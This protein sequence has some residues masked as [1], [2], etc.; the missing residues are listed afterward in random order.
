VVRP[1]YR[2]AVRLYSIADARWPHIDAAYPDVDLL[3][4]P[5]DRFLNLVYAWSA[6]RVA[7]DR[8]EQWEKEMDDPLPGER[9]SVTREPTEAELDTEGE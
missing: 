9:V 8:Y 7:P 1:P 5:V 4:L 2:R 3:S 6:S